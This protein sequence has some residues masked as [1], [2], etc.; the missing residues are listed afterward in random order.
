MDRLSQV[1]SE[2]VAVQYCLFLLS[3]RGVTL[4][5]VGVVDVLKNTRCHHVRVEETRPRE[6]EIHDSKHK[7]QHYKV[8]FEEAYLEEAQ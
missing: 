3:L 5:E 7:L 4:P 8:A 1:H 6:E 2:W